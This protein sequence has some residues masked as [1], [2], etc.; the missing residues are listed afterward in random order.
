MVPR[1]KKHDKE[2]LVTLNY[3]KINYLY[4]IHVQY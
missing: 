3:Y 4:Q 2:S 1:F